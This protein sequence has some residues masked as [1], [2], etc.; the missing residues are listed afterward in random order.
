MR[1]LK[2]IIKASNQK[3]VELEGL[4]RFSLGFTLRPPLSQGPGLNRL[5]ILLHSFE[6]GG[7]KPRGGPNASWTV[8]EYLKAHL[9]REG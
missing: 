8:F 1:Y 4:F 7:G 6:E 9:R 5:T 2:F 3:Q